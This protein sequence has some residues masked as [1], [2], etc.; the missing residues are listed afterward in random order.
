MTRSD[1]HRLRRGRAVAALVRMGWRPP[2]LT[3]RQA[4]RLLDDI[5][6]AQP[7]ELSDRERR[8][9]QSFADG[10]T[11][12]QTADMLGI[13]AETVKDTAERIRLKLGANNTANAVARGLRRGLIR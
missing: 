9:L 1:D 13:P 11:R 6:A 12:D 2:P 8:V 10:G 7:V 5:Q 3:D 4:A